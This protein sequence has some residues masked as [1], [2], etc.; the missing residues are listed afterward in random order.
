MI[1]CE[2]CGER[3]ATGVRQSSLPVPYSAAYCDECTA[4]GVEPAGIV[5]ATRSLLADGLI[6]PLPPEVL[7]RLDEKRDR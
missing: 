4:L 2:V 1:I 3:P 6:E 7:K 5:D